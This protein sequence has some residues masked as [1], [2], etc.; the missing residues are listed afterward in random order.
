MSR[1]KRIAE[2]A[3][4]AYAS[5]K[6]LWVLQPTQDACEIPE[7]A[8][9]LTWLRAQKDACSADPEKRLVGAQE[10]GAMLTAYAALAWSL[11]ES[12]GTLH[13]A[14]PDTFWPCV[15]EAATFF[16]GVP[17]THKLADYD[18]IIL[19]SLLRGRAFVTLEVA[20]QGLA[21]V[22]SSSACNFLPGLEEYFEL[23]DKYALQARLINQLPSSFSIRPHPSHPALEVSLAK[24]PC[25]P[26]PATPTRATHPITAQQLARYKEQ[27]QQACTRHPSLQQ[28]LEQQ[29]VQGYVLKPRWGGY[30]EGVQ[31]FR[32]G[33]GASAT[34]LT[35]ARLNALFSQPAHAG[36]DF[37]MEPLVEQLMQL[38]HRLYLTHSNDAWQVDTYSTQ[39]GVMATQFMK[40]NYVTDVTAVRGTTVSF[41][42]SMNPT[43]AALLLAA[44]QHV[45]AAL[46]SGRGLTFNTVAQLLLRVDMCCCCLVD[47]THVVVVNE[48]DQFNTGWLYLK[49]EGGSEQQHNHLRMF[50]SLSEQLQKHLKLCI[51][52]RKNFTGSR[53]M[54][55]GQ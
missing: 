39:P 10:E 28:L 40:P 43:K 17:S 22:H 20:R 15:A 3:N 8:D 5:A 26:F 19:P 38:E 24:L 47:G 42:I 30:G 13:L 51:A 55:K 1:Y 36:M 14:S 18:L 23:A 31:I 29:Q 45:K 2:L 27:L 12:I 34:P 32:N 11:R 44:A 4:Q 6:V 48:V 9:A 16:C 52:E 50:K 21:H 46:M 53:K 7:A 25:L 41:S 49:G 37:F 54:L 33:T 35:P